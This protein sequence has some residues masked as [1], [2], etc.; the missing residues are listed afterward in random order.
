MGKFM[1]EYWALAAQNAQFINLYTL[2][3]NLLPISKENALEAQHYMKQINRLL[4]YSDRAPAYDA[5]VIIDGVKK[6]VTATLA[7]YNQPFYVW[8]S[9]ANNK[10]VYRVVFMGD[11][12][13]DK[14]ATIIN[15]GRIGNGVIISYQG[16][17][18]EIPGGLIDH[19][20]ASDPL[21]PFGFYVTQ[22]L[23]TGKL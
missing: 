4:G 9:I 20:S 22:P 11:N 7:E 12:N 3:T 1:Y 18:L 16:K 8:A 15:D 2:S 10:R 5:S 19:E 21:T 17:Q 13:F 14:S 6:D 23:E